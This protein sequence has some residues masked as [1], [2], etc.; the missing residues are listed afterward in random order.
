MCS[1]KQVSD[2]IPAGRYDDFL[3]ESGSWAVEIRDY[4]EDINSIIPE[5][6]PPDPDPSEAYRAAVFLEGFI[7]DHQSKGMW[8]NDTL[9]RFDSFGSTVEVE[10]VAKA[11]RET[12]NY[13]AD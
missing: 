6:I 3:D 8:S 5:D 12:A 7:E 4:R 9:R 1:Y 13:S 10:A 11:L 2:F